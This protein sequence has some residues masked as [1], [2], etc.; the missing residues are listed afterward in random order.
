M[1]K[2]G[3]MTNGSRRTNP[4]FPSKHK[5]YSISLILMEKID[6]FI[7]GKKLIYYKYRSS[8][9]RLFINKK[10]LLLKSLKSSEEL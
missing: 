8:N 2:M 7:T 6:L 3:N 1:I 9:S 4:F 5:Q 10:N